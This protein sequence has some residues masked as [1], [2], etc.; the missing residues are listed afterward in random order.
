MHITKHTK[1]L[2][3]WCR[4]KFSKACL[5]RFRC[6]TDLILVFSPVLWRESWAENRIRLHL[7]QTRFLVSQ[8]QDLHLTM[9]IS[10][11]LECYIHFY[12]FLLVF[13]IN[14]ECTEKE[15]CRLVLANVCHLFSSIASRRLQHVITLQH[16]KRLKQLK[17]KTFSIT[18]LKFHI[19]F[20]CRDPKVINT[21]IKLYNKM[22]LIMSSLF[23]HVFSCLFIYFCEIKEMCCPV[24]V[25]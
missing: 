12:Y 5:S 11:F 3:T 13:C 17:S 10:P 6:L 15:I 18:F 9:V 2:H 14:S 19:C 1:A 25:Q 21:D 16:L 7:K 20:C 8:I 4:V 22:Y 23:I 24:S